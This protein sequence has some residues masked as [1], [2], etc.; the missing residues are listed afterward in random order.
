[1]EVQGQADPF[2]RQPLLH[3]RKKNKQLN[4]CDEIK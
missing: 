2:V 3:E 4:R 1:M